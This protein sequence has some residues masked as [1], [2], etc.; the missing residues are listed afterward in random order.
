MILSI[1][2]NNTKYSFKDSKI[3]YKELVYNKINYYNFIIND[4]IICTKRDLIEFQCKTC[5]SI[6]IIK[7][8]DYKLKKNKHL[9]KKLGYNIIVFDEDEFKKWK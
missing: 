5:T 3:E 1:I 7:I 9:C 2:K 6:E 4:K 8:Q